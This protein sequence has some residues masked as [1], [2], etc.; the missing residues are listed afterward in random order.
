MMSM[1]I[2]QGLLSLGFHHYTLTNLQTPKDPN[3]KEKKLFRIMSYGPFLF[4]SLNFIKLNKHLGGRKV[5]QLRVIIII[6]GDRAFWK[7]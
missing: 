4:L 6:S 5:L 2:N 7:A 1:V 3:T